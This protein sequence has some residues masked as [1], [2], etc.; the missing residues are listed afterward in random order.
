MVWGGWGIRGVEPNPDFWWALNHQRHVWSDQVPSSLSSE[1]AD[2][3]TLPLPGCAGWDGGMQLS[4][5]PLCIQAMVGREERADHPAQSSCV[6]QGY[7]ELPPAAGPP[8]AKTPPTSQFHADLTR[9]PFSFSSSHKNHT[10]LLKSPYPRALKK[11]SPECWCWLI[12]IAWGGSLA[13]I[14]HLQCPTLGRAK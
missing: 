14:I 5:A 6:V 2:S 4:P 3:N 13:L 9:F 11:K 12:E 1:W 7:G 10:H 8:W